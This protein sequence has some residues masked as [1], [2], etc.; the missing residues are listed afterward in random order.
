VVGNPLVLHPAAVH[1]AVLVVA[2]EPFGGT[3]WTLF[4]DSHLWLPLE[5]VGAASI[6]IE[7]DA[8]YK[9]GIWK[10]AGRG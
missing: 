2:A 9:I 1:H 4:I 10:I 3:E 5:I 6:R 8:C 7:T